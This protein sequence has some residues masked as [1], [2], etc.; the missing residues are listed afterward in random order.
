MSIFDQLREGIKWTWYIPHKPYAKQLAFLM[1]P[2]REAFYGGAA[3]GGKSDALLMGALQWVDTPGYSA[4]LF[5]KK[6]TDNSLIPRAKEW[7]AGTDAV[8]KGGQTHGRG[9]HFVFPSGAILEFGHC[10][11]EGAIVR[12]Q[13]YEYQYIGFDEVTH[14]FLEEYTYMF[15]RLR[16]PQCQE[17]KKNP[18]P[19]CP[20]C[21]E[22]SALNRIPLR[23][24]CASNPGCVGHKWVKDRFRIE[25]DRKT[26]LFLGK[27]PT[28]P[29]V[30]AF[31][32]DNKALDIAEYEASFD[33]ADLDPVTAEQLRK[34]DWSVS[35]DS[36]FRQSWAQYYNLQH[37]HIVLRPTKGRVR[38]FL[39]SQCQV[40]TTVDPAASVREGPGDADIWRRSPSY[41]VISTWLETPDHDLIWWDIDRFRK[42][43]PDLL[44]ALKQNYVKHSPEFQGIEAD[45]LGIGVYQMASRIGLPVRALHSHGQDK[46]VRATDACNRMAAGKVWLPAAS[47]DRPWLRE[48]ESE[49]FTWTGHPHE[50][51]DQ[52]DTLSHAAKIVSEDAAGTEGN[53]FQNPR[54][55]LP[56]VF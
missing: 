2:Q 29:Y 46:L 35:H 1:L 27:D 20:L 8:F 47:L 56:T 15:T 23:I 25:L 34:G 53:E 22:Y 18:N 49:L 30:P 45:G 39:L 28:R 5:R 40:F 6:Y 9:P 7:L 11:H 4:I 24:R 36:R 31:F 37:G 14:F 44:E 50:Q 21:R 51:A 33:Q 12:Y 54:E 32:T 10:D 52:I 48:L 17:H 13:G 26:G 16:K 3:G 42:E 43:I 19:E 55:D 38:T 41:S